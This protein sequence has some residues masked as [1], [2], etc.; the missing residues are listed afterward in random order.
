MLYSLSNLLCSCPHLLIFYL[1]NIYISLALILCLKSFY[2]WWIVQNHFKFFAKWNRVNN[3]T[4]ISHMHRES[5]NR[6]IASFHW[7]YF[8]TRLLWFAWISSQF[9]YEV[10]PSEMIDHKTVRSLE[11]RLLRDWWPW[12]R[13]GDGV[14][15]HGNLI[16]HLT[17]YLFFVF[18]GKWEYCLPCSLWKFMN[19]GTSSTQLTMRKQGVAFNC[20]LVTSQLFLTLVPWQA[21][22]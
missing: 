13:L 9:F 12:F 21:T 22:I 16:R 8:N 20:W 2:I 5:C 11:E 6:F 1:H 10:W 19:H 7:I 15:P 14:L 17:M 4:F 3:S 18:Y